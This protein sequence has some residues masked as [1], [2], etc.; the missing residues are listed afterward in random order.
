MGA[1]LVDL[2]GGISRRPPVCDSV[3]QGYV[4]GGG[5][6]AAGGVSFACCFHLQQHA[7]DGAYGQAA[8]RHVPDGRDDLEDWW[9][10]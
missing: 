5:A 10:D 1:R 3:A 7:V 8:E 6:V 9:C 4:Q 2:V